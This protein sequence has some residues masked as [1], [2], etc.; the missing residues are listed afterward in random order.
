M[1]D[2]ASRWLTVLTWIATV[3]FVVGC[4]DDT[5]K[6]CDEVPPSVFLLHTSPENL[7]HNL[8]LA[9]EERNLSRCDSL[10]ARDYRFRFTPHDQ[11]RPGFP[12]SLS[13]MDEHEIHLQLL[14]RELTP[15]LRLDF[16]IGEIALDQDRLLSGDS[17]WTT[18]VTE[19][20]LYIFGARPNRYS[21]LEWYGFEGDHQQFWFRKESEMDP[22]TNERVWS[23]VEWAD[24][25]WP[26]T[27]PGNHALP[28][29]TPLSWGQIK[30]KYLSRH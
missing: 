28:P 19:V 24:L 15:T 5:C 21:T 30:M 20:D 2:K 3:L 6:P 23:I 14:D 1:I 11:E 22:S 27:L 13:W 18:I 7:L 9:Y 10:F 25:G 12:D 4:S 16:E 29:P 26:G 17:L 8:I